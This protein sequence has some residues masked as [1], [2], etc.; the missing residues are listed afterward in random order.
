MHSI[1]L[2]YMYVQ[3]NQ[4]QKPI[5]TRDTRICYNWE[6]AYWQRFS[7]E[8][9]VTATIEYSDKFVEAV[10]IA[11]RNIPGMNKDI[12]NRYTGYVEKFDKNQ[13]ED[14]TNKM[15][16]EIAGQIGDTRRNEWQ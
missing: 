8:L 11:S 9:A 14:K 12:L 13:F 1:D 4:L 10:K 16:L 3:S 5:I 7:K 2:L 15:G 6:K